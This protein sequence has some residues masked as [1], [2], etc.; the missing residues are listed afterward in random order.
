MPS[1]RTEAPEAHAVMISSS[2]LVW[3]DCLPY[4][5]LRGGSNARESQWKTRSMV[6]SS[7]ARQN[8]MTALSSTW[9]AIS[10]NA[11]PLTRRASLPVVM[12]A[13]TKRWMSS[14]LAT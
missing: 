5:A 13:A 1:S 12:S 9:G 10:Q 6:N 11:S 2:R 3:P 4:W 14:S 7:S 8:L